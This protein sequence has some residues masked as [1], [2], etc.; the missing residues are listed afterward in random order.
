MN[1]EGI[2]ARH[3]HLWLL[4][5]LA[6]L[7]TL[8]ALCT[9]MYLPGFPA[10]AHSFHV[11]ISALQLTFASFSLG[12][13]L[14]Q[15]FYGPISDRFGRRLPVLFG[16]ILFIAS[17]VLCGTATNLSELI[18][19]RFLQ[20]LGGAGGMVIARAIVR[21]RLSGIEM[22]KMMSAMGMI[23]V[24]SPTL[25]PS[26]GSLILRFGHWPWIFIG[27][28]IF[29]VIILI[30]T[31]GIQES[32]PPEN[33]NEHGVKQALKSYREITQSHEWR[34]AALI[35][36]GGGFLTFGYVSS[37][38][39]VLIGTYHVST[40]NY[41][42]L[43]ALISIGLLTSNRVNIKFLHRVGLMGMLKRFTLVQ[44]VAASL[45]LVASIFQAPLWILLTLIVICFGC[46]PGMSGNAMTLAMHPFP[47]KAG[48]A[49]AM[50][51]LAQFFGSGF[52]AAALAVI[53]GNVLIKMGIAMVVGASIS[54]VQVRRIKEA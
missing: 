36:I 35:A 47:D 23:F 41:G 15:L 31:L 50:I 1:K 4:I 44:T 10:V 49:S 8:P 42:L 21:D 2:K 11:Q 46:A 48:S 40:G 34:S 32:L 39:A 3:S 24:L 22:A 37:S 52:I 51:G 7:T 38:A 12:A 30:G 43:F 25:A 26:I 16:L 27:L 45:V 14:G 18:I 28:A 13:G 5:T 17:S 54:F 6:G 53:H 29:G 9:D 19:Y 20:A 33:R